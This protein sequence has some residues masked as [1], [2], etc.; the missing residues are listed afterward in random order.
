MRKEKEISILIE[1]Y[2][3][4]LFFKKSFYKQNMIDNDKHSAFNYVQIHDTITI[5]H[6]TYTIIDRRL[7]N[8]Q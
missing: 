1:F 6:K 3:D 2:T 4:E 8:N 5:T 7:Q